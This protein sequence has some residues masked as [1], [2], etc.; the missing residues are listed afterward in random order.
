MA[1]TRRAFLQ[2]SVATHGVRDWQS[3]IRTAGT[4]AEGARGVARH[5]PA[6][7]RRRLRPDR[8][9]RPTCAQIVKRYA[10]NSERCARASARRSASP[11]G[12][13]RSRRSI[14]IRTARAERAD[15]RLHPWRRVAQRARQGLRLSGRDCSCTRARISWCLI[16]TTCW[17]PSGDLMPMAEQ[18]RR[19]VA[20]VYSNAASFGGDPNRIYRLRP[21]LRR[22]SRRRRAG[23]RLAEGFRPAGGRRQGRAVLLS[24][25]FD[26]KPVRL[27]ARSSYVK[28][29]DEVE[30]ALSPQ[31][32]L[33]Q[34]NC[35]GRSSPT[36]RWRRPSSSASRAISRRP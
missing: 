7:A 34:L 12:R 19:A 25:M 5:G 8:N 36:A 22:P 21:L 13:P 14:S 16:S 2:A 3:C 27:S 11:T 9:T 15:P 29:T 1:V 31:R 35:S 24:G 30:Q 28:F 26:L 4:P 17:R 10:T 32:H 23:H 6:G 18:V 33:D 20:W